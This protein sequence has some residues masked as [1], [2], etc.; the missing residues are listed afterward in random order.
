MNADRLP[1]KSVP[2]DRFSLSRFDGRLNQDTLRALAYVMTVD[3]PF[4]PNGSE[5]LAK[6][7]GWDLATA[8]GVL[9]KLEKLGWLKSSGPDSWEIRVPNGLASSSREGTGASLS[10]ASRKR[11]ITLQEALAM[12]GSEPLYLLASE[13]KAKGLPPL[14]DPELQ[15]LVDIVRQTQP[16]VVN[17]YWPGYKEMSRVTGMS[18]KQIKKVMQSLKRRGYVVD[19]GKGGFV[20]CV[21]ASSLFR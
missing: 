15:R 7:L 19:D 3:L 14:D 17:H 12:S 18:R 6:A 9:E 1:L 4:V 16:V 21:P 8:K 5:N 13:E 10:H 2:D 20:P 11:E